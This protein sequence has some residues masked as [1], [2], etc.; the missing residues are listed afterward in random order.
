MLSKK[1]YI[2]CIENEEFII[3][4]LVITIKKLSF[5]TTLRPKF[6]MHKK[7]LT[8]KKNHHS[9][10]TSKKAYPELMTSAK[11]APLLRGSKCCF[12]LKLGFTAITW[13]VLGEKGNRLSFHPSVMP[14]ETQ[15]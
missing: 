3:P 11:S 4:T 6:K 14:P 5:K 9:N 13:Y 2:I 12:Y 15:Y 8:T 7:I 10:T 1:Y